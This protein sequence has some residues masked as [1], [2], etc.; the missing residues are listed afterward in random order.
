VP[1]QALSDFEERLSEIDQLIEAHG[2]LTR[3]RRAE[4]AL[5]DAGQ[6]LQAV[7][8]VV[9]ALVTPPGVGRPAEVQALNK[10]AIALLSAHLQGYVEDVFEEVGRALLNGRVPQVDALL[11]QAPKRGNP[12]WDNISRLFSA[13]GFPAIL[14]GLSWQGTS[15]AALKTRL[16]QLNELRNRIVH[17]AA[18]S[19]RK[20]TVQTYVGFVRQFSARLDRKVAQV[21]RGLVGQD[22]W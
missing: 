5:E 22:P 16:R 11:M 17:G 15:N 19:V 2:A 14:D 18:E 8:Q 20:R 3:L 1:S 4:A 6:S 9:N 21:Y 13:L 10:A 12:N 7:A